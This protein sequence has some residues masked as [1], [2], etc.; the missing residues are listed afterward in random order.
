MTR[1]AADLERVHH[2]CRQ[3]GV[4]VILIGHDQRVGAALVQRQPG[5]MQAVGIACQFQAQNISL[6]TPPCRPRCTNP[7]LRSDACV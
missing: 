7:F 3:H 6:S 1:A 4:Q 2:A 5:N